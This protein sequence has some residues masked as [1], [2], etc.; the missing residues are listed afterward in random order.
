MGTYTTFKFE[1]KIDRAIEQPLLKMGKAYM[2]TWGDIYPITDD[3]FYETRLDLGLT[4]DFWSDCRLY[5][6]L[7][8]VTR[9]LRRRAGKLMVV[10]DDELKNYTDTMEKFLDLIAPHVRGP[11]GT[12]LG[13]SSHIEDDYDIHYFL[14]EHPDGTRYAKEVFKYHSDPHISQFGVSAA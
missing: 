8:T 1:F 7:P 10:L 13:M 14:E 12:Y 3:P 9:P 4:H 11:V 2:G 5:H 6:F